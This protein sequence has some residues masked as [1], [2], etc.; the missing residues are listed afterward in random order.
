MA[1]IKRCE[2]TEC[3]N[4]EDGYCDCQIIMLSG[5]ACNRYSVQK[6]DKQNG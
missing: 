3:Q 4:N 2:A 6:E 1:E 5:G